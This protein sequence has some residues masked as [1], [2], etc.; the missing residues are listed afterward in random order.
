MRLVSL[1][2][3][4]FGFWVA[5]SGQFKPLLLTLGV[6]SALACVGV[7]ARIRIVDREGHPIALLPRTLLYFPWLIKQVFRTGWHV[8]KIILNPALPISPTMTTVRGN[9]KTSAGLATYANSITLTVGSVVARISGHELTVHALQREGALELEE[10]E[11]D[12]R[13][14][15][16]E[17]GD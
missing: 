11:M 13:V 15:R 6:L 3:F 9:Q 16:F 4:L 12:R 10:G 7:A 8:A 17:G 14:C 2:L 5:M 1:A